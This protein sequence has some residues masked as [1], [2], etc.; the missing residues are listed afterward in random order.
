MSAAPPYIGTINATHRVPGPPRPRVRDHVDPRALN[1]GLAYNLEYTEP[2]V[3]ELGERNR[4]LSSE[5][6]I[7]VSGENEITGVSLIGRHPHDSSKVI[8]VT[9]VGADHDQAEEAAER[10]WLDYHAAVAFAER[11]VEDVIRNLTV[12]HPIPGAL[13]PRKP[14]AVAFNLSDLDEPVEQMIARN[15]PTS[16]VYHVVECGDLTLMRVDLYGWHPVH[17]GQRICVVGIADRHYRAVA[18]AEEAWKNYHASILLTA[19]AW[20]DFAAATGLRL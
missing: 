3:R 15:A 17:P 1:A 16:D 20:A 11:G 4:P 7:A 19:N 8:S 10:A 9:G 2:L 18:A 13:V 12:Q 5:R 14:A 6:R